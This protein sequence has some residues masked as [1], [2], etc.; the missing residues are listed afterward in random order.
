[1]RCTQCLQEMSFSSSDSR[2]HDKTGKQGAKTDQNWK[3]TMYFDPEA[4][5]RTGADYEIEDEQLVEKMSQLVDAA[6]MIQSVQAYKGPLGWFQLTK[7]VFYHEFIVFTTKNYYWSIEKHSD[8]I[9]IQRA[10]LRCNVE[11]RFRHNPRFEG[12][13]GITLMKSAAGTK[14]IKQLIDWLYINRELYKHYTFFEWN[15]QCFAERVYNYV[16]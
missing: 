12:F 3:Y 14:S 13:S 10:K 11:Q 15:C 1:M 9:T 16:T 4:D 7:A 5:R 8:C 2:S 6:E